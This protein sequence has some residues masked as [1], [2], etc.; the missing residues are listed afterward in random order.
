MIAPPTDEGLRRLLRARGLSADE[1]ERL[2]RSWT[3]AVVETTHRS[4]VRSSAARRY[5]SSVLAFASG[6]GGAAP[7]EV[8]R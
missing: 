5:V 8:P 4:P 3:A 7:Q 6:A 2:V 1:A